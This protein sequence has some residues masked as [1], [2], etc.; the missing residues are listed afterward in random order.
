MEVPG[1]IELVLVEFCG[2]GGGGSGGGCGVC[3]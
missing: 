3:K 1:E 2:H